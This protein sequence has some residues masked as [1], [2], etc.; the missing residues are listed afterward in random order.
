[1][2][3]TFGHALDNFD[4]AVSPAADAADNNV[5]VTP[6]AEFVSHAIYE[7][8]PEASTGVALPDATPYLA[9]NTYLV[10]PGREAAFEAAIARIATDSPRR[11]SLFRLRIGGLTSQYVHM[12]PAGTLAASASLP[13]IR[14]PE[15]LVQH[16]HS[17][18]LRYQPQMSY[19]P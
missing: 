2:D 16:A 5:N 7:R 4:H 18:L 9:L 13:E 1:M 3:G 19:A 14:L 11:M 8:L 12:R 15:L 10:V 17:E 6:Y